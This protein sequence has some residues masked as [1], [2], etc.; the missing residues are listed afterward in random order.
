MPQTESCS[1]T[2]VRRLCHL[3][4][5]SHAKKQLTS[6][7]QYSFIK[8]KLMTSYVYSW[9][10]FWYASSALPMCCISLSYFITRVKWCLLLG[11]FLFPWPLQCQRSEVKS[12]MY[13]LYTKQSHS[14][15][16]LISFF[17]FCQLVPN[18]Y[19]WPTNCFTSLKEHKLEN[20]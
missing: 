16:A 8:T 17:M 11:S 14:R 6:S 2:S 15:W 4:K 13:F 10:S 3:Y 19:Y 20:K 1:F 5:T 12:K 9:W 18:I 7:R